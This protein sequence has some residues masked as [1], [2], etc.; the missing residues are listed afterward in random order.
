MNKHTNLL[1][2]SL[3]LVSSGLY[4]IHERG[5]NNDKFNL[6]NSWGAELHVKIM[7]PAGKLIKGPTTVKA[8]DNLSMPQIPQVVFAHYPSIE[9]S[10]CGIVLKPDELK[11][12]KVER[13]YLIVRPIRDKVS[14]LP[15]KG[16]KN[17]ISTKSIRSAKKE[18]KDWKKK[19]E[20]K[21]TPVIEKVIEVKEIT[22]ETPV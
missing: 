20:E 1:L 12:E 18:Y 13:V 6:T 14:F 2:I 3:F 8:G 4:A 9:D 7:N 21:K 17:N 15:L 16:I 11:K 5:T 22:T 10:K 19:L